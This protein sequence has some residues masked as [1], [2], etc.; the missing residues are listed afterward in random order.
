MDFVQLCSPFGG[1]LFT[2]EYRGD[3]RKGEENLKHIASSL[4]RDSDAESL[5]AFTLQQSCLCML[6]GNNAEAMTHIERLEQCPNLNP[7]WKLRKEI[8]RI[9]CVILR[10]YP[11]IIRHI[12]SGLNQPWGVKVP[13]I[14]VSREISE[15]FAQYRR[16][17]K[18]DDTITFECSFLL[19]AINFPGFLRTVHVRNPKYPIGKGGRVYQEMKQKVIERF[20]TLQW[21][22]KACANAGMQRLSQYLK[23]LEVELHF[24]IGSSDKGIDGLRALESEYELS[25]DWAGC[26][27]CKLLE[28]DFALTSPFSTPFAFNLIPVYSG[29]AGFVC[30]VWDETEDKLSL[31]ESDEWSQRLLQQAHNLFQRSDSPRGCAAVRLRQ[32]CIEHMKCYS[33]ACMPN[34][35]T[36]FLQAA[37]ERF[38]D[39]LHLFDL[40]EVHCQIVRGHQMM[41]M[42]SGQEDMKT[43][44]SLARDIGSW[45]IRSNNEGISEFIGSLLIRFGRRLL[46]QSEVNKA[47]MCFEAARE[48][49]SA[50]E[51]QYGTF[52]AMISTI[53]VHSLTQNNL[54]A[55]YLIEHQTESF[56]ALLNYFDGL[57]DSDPLYSGFHGTKV[58]VITSYDSV[59]SP[60]Y[61][62]L[63]EFEALKKWR[64]EVKQLL[65]KDNMTMTIALRE[66]LS[67]PFFNNY[68]GK[69]GHLLVTVSSSWASPSFNIFRSASTLVKRLV[70]LGLSYL[71]GSSGSSSNEHVSEPE[72]RE[73]TF[74][75]KLHRAHSIMDDYAIMIGRYRDLILTANV[76]E[77]ENV[78]RSFYASLESMAPAFSTKVAGILVGSELG[79]LNITSK[80]LE[81]LTDEELLGEWTMDKYGALH[82]TQTRSS[83]VHQHYRSQ[84]HFENAL[85]FCVLA[86]Q[87]DRGY[88]FL[89]IIESTDPDFFDIRGWRDVDMWHRFASAG[90]IAGH[91]GEIEKGFKYLLQA[92]KMVECFRGNISDKE[93]RRSMISTAPI[94]NITNA[95]IFLCLECRK[96]GLP[97]N[98]IFNSDFQDHSDART[99]EEN[100]LLFYERS[101]ARSLLDSLR[102]QELGER[103]TVAEAN[104][105]KRYK[106]AKLRHLRS[107]AIEHRMQGIEMPEMDQ[108]EL[109]M[110][111]NELGPDDSV[112]DFQQPMLSI[113]LNIDPRDL[114][115]AIPDDALVIAISYSLEAIYELAITAHKGVLFAEKI[116]D[117]PA[118]FRRSAIR[119]L[120]YIR[121]SKS[122]TVM[123]QNMTSAP[124]R[125]LLQ[126]LSAAIILPV[127][128]LIRSKNH[129]IFVMSFPLIGFPVGALALDGKP[130]CI[131][132]AISQ[133]P[134][135][136]SLLY[137]SKRTADKPGTYQQKSQFVS[138][139]SKVSSWAEYEAKPTEPPLPMA[140]I[141]S[142]AISHLFNIQPIKANEMD[143]ERFRKVLNESRVLHVATH[144]V[145][146]S[147]SLWTMNLLLKEKVRAFDLFET[148]SNADLVVFSACSTGIGTVVGNE[149]LGFSHVLLEAGCSSYLGALWEV[150][151]VAT[152]LMMVLFFRKIR[153][154]IDDSNS[155]VSVAELWR[156]ALE[157]F[158]NMNPKRA[159]G[160][161][162]DLIH[163]WKNTAPAA[164]RIVQGGMIYLKKLSQYTSTEMDMDV[165]QGVEDSTDPLDLNFQH[166]YLYASF[167][168]IGNGAL[169]LLRSK[170]CRVRSP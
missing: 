3:I 14:S 63:G 54:H 162:Q 76:D 101:R 30:Q 57:R 11:P 82:H 97:L 84:P 74:F 37:K 133:I 123:T 163:I 102:S 88:K 117:L 41:L 61:R 89:H 140:G 160:I 78:L 38:S 6:R 34:E 68:F 65:K 19:A 127:Q 29:N 46:Y 5:A 28:A 120:R 145:F 141:E 167:T 135:L 21:C 166:P 72:Q 71:T 53:T 131:Q 146:E 157:D 52:Q 4:N 36:G 137:L 170:E 43:V 66:A 128:G 165:Y 70:T 98:L 108:Q 158:Y 153:Q 73:E 45:G 125:D 109:N 143:R 17:T 9:L 132:K 142:V 27:A 144:G 2:E 79:D 10:R 95:L 60:I 85:Y 7:R 48:C 23:R 104:T 148:Q 50:M 168:L 1:S 83:N 118:Q 67:D 113:S 80:N 154:C 62:S 64:A 32:G 47:L 15:A 116:N 87:W 40:D 16:D 136:S 134:S 94:I 33:S 58:N 69:A 92:M 155:N 81:L 100:V 59:V 111:E 90:V 122:M 49:F 152:M 93:A 31:L 112:L 13:I 149:V 44:T 159:R 138:S 121:E 56:Y 99:W 139:I 105:N 77:A 86:G 115:G 91:K 103:L 25:G 147:R 75:D 164:R 39:A 42:I 24:A 114:Y 106:Q 12:P 18:V 96:S 156:L 130:L 8:Y 161:I 55:R 26:A 119:L 35:R 110:L 169:R 129:I 150:N 107:L 151:D 124:I 20:E 51:E 126:E 22:Q